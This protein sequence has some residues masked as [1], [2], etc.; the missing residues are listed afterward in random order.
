MRFMTMCG[1]IAGL[2]MARASFA[3][4]A[5]AGTASAAATDAKPR[6]IVLT[7]I[8]EP[9]FEPDDQQSLVRLLVYANVL[10]TRD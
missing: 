4:A 2:I 7:D 3:I 6:V 5:D 9:N 10:D 1:I 8:N